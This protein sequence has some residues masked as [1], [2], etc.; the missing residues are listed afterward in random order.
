MVIKD[1]DINGGEDPRKGGKSKN[2]DFIAQAFA[3]NHSIT[4]SSD[5]SNYPSDLHASRRGVLFGIDE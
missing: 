3:V 2:H 5:I 4:F 1:Y